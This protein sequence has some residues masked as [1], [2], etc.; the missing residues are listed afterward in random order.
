MASDSLAIPLDADHFGVRLLVP[1]ASLFACIGTYGIGLQLSA[2]SD[3]SNLLIFLVLPISIAVSLVVAWGVER[4]A[5]RYWPSGR[6][7]IIDDSHL[8]M[9]EAK[10]PDVTLDWSQHINVLSW[11]FTVPP[12]RGR[13]PKDWKC[14]AC[15]LLQDED[16]ITLY[17]FMKPEEAE[18]LEVYY[19]FTVLTRRKDLEEEGAWLKSGIQARLHSAEQIRWEFGA[20]MAPEDFTLLV[21]MMRE[22]I[23][24]WPEQSGSAW[25]GASQ[26]PSE[27]RERPPSKGDGKPIQ[28]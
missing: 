25:A 21:D 2:G 20:E 8:T 13:V 3:N 11:R 26:A 14:L 6:A 22:R 15:Q 23:E 18:K 28:L 24:S 9:Q 27:S 7:L 12:R 10:A 4:L 5:K 16:S 17:T 1:A 19:A